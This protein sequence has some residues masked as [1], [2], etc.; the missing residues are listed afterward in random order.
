[1]IES[2]N[3]IN[4]KEAFQKFAAAFG[5]TLP[6]QSVQV[7]KTKQRLTHQLVSFVFFTVP[8]HQQLS[9]DDFVW[10]HA[11]ELRKRAFPKTLKEFI[12]KQL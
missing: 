11:D 2:S 12:E 9:V 5:I 4:K 1:M 10:L 8:I 3:P 6:E 7:Y